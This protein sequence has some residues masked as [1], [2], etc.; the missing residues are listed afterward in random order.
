MLL[1]WSY[2]THLLCCIVLTAEKLSPHTLTS[3][4]T[5]TPLCHMEAVLHGRTAPCIA[6]LVSVLQGKTHCSAGLFTDDADLHSLAQ[7]YNYTL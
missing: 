4:R 6:G 7:G 2:V 1:H 5:Y 3:K